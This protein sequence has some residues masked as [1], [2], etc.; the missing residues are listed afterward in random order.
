MPEECGE[1]GFGVGMVAV[2]LHFDI[3]SGDHCFHDFISC[4]CGSHFALLV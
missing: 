4:C 1:L 2:G 3:V